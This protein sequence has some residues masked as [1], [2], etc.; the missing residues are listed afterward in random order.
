MSFLKFRRKPPSA[1]AEVSGAGGNSALQ[2]QETV[3]D[4]RRR[5]RHRLIG[6]VFLVIIAVLAFPLLFETEPRPDSS[7]TPIGVAD[8]DGSAPL[9]IATGPDMDTVP[10]TGGLDPD[11]ELLD[12]SEPEP[13]PSTVA[14]ATI[15]EQP[16]TDQDL[17]SAAPEEVEDA[18]DPDDELDADMGEPGRPGKVR[19]ASASDA[20]A[21]QTGSASEPASRPQAESPAAPGT[22]QVAAAS[23]AEQAERERRQREQAALQQRQQQEAER[24]RKALSGSE[25][26]SGA[27]P[28]P[29]AS[30]QRF[31]VQIGAYAE[32]DTVRRVRATAEQ[33][34]LPTFTQEIQVGG[35]SQIRVR[36]GPFNSRAAAEG[37]VSTLRKAGLGGQVLTL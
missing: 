23:Q 25:S 12:E 24:A 7:A 22:G 15:P 16:A 29:T 27:V 35:A 4:L 32:P 17:A 20:P 19:V 30:A 26:A 6:A 9:E 14:S 18:A 3:A 28:A 10:L 5:A 8:S 21:A 33:H 11:E 1:A 31:V 36:V 37:A 34:G 2:R 13:E